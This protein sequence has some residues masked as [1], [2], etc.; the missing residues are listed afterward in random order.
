MEVK[1]WKQSLSILLFPVGFVLAFVLIGSVIGTSQSSEKKLQETYLGQTI[2]VQSPSLAQTFQF[3]VN[4]ISAKGCVP[5]PIGLAHFY[6]TV[7]IE[8]PQG[9]KYLGAAHGSTA[10]NWQ[11]DDGTGFTWFLDD[12]RL[13]EDI[14]TPCGIDIH[15]TGVDV[16]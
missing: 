4:F 11:R 7:I 14:V 9:T 6:G 12:L 13:P 16:K 5:S 2:K 15:I 8:R 3:K 1:M 10:V